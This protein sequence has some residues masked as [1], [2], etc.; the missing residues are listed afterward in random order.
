MNRRQFLGAAIFSSAAFLKHNML[1][2]PDINTSGIPQSDW[3]VEI[4][5]SSQDGGVPHIGC[6]CE[7]CDYYRKNQL[8]LFAASLGLYDLKNERFFL[9]D[10]TPDIKRQLEHAEKRHMVDKKHLPLKF[11]PDGIFLTHA[12]MGHYTGLM[13]YGFE[14]INSKGLPVFCSEKMSEYLRKNGP[15]S[16][17]VKYK[18]IV[19]NIVGSET[20]TDL[21]D[22]C[23]IIPY[24]VPHRQEYS[25]T[26]CFRIEGPDRSVLYIPDIDRWEHWDRQ[27]AEE[28]RQVDTALLDGTFFADGELPGRDMSKIPH[29]TVRSTMELLRD[30]VERGKTKVY[31][32]HLNHSNPLVIPES[33]ETRYVLKQG[34]Y[35]AREGM[36][37]EL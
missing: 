20:V 19:L 11:T 4:L 24:S 29:P 36:L 8:K 2:D 27:I 31:F 33:D 23:K 21:G 25:D 18:N 16:Q 26:L 6:K 34:F 3:V 22:G 7:R 37:F 9:F 17:L 5:G 1:A 15:W 35:V 12:H 28:V 13:Y 14:S 32:T 30:I 10:A